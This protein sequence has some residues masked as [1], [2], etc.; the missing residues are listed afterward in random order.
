MDK[1]TKAQRAALEKALEVLIDY[2]GDF[3]EE[4]REIAQML[5][6]SDLKFFEM[7]GTSLEY[8]PEEHEDKMIAHYTDMLYPFRNKW[9]EGA[10]YVI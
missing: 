5:G 9:R 1:L 3:I 7:T 2:E 8:C 4:C 10:D 6:M